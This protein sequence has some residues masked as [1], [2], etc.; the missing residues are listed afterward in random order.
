VLT[1]I[2]SFRELNHCGLSQRQVSHRTA[3]GTLMAFLILLNFAGCQQA[4]TS[5]SSNSSNPTTTASQISG[6]VTTLAGSGAAGYAD[7][8]G[9]AAIFNGNRGLARV[10]NTLYVAD[11]SNNMIRK[12]VIGTGVVTTLAGSTTPGATNGTGSAASFN[13]PVGLDTDGTNL[14]VTDNNNN[15]IRQ[16]VISTGVVTTLAGSGV[17]GSTNGTGTGASF[18]DP[19]SVLVVGGNLFVGSLN[20]DLV[21]QIVISTGLVTTL[22]GS[23]AAGSTNGTGTGASFSSPKGMATDGTNLYVADYGNNLIRKIVI[24][25]GVVTTLAGSGAAALTDGNGTAAAFHGPV[26]VVTDGTNLFIADALNNAIRKVV[27]GSVAV[28]TLAGSGTAGSTNGTGTGASFSLPTWLA[29]NTSTPALFVSDSSN[30]LVR[31]IQ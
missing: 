28:T 14:Y 21:R 25:T 31:L 19:N 26:G 5:S 12:L 23:G 2:S 10:G 27:I 8:T 29:I 4:T 18:N 7:G 20:D 30:N 24:S 13:F 11:S 9:A 6:V 17:A 16:I 22:A 1:Q 15:L 3:Y